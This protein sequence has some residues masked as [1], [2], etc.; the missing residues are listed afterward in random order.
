MPARDAVELKL[1]RLPVVVPVSIEVD[2]RFRS[3]PPDA[4]TDV[5]CEMLSAWPVVRAFTTIDCPIPVVSAEAVRRTCVPA[6]D[7]VDERFTSAP[8]VVAV[9]IE[10]EDTLRSAPPEAMTAVV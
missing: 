5:V 2:E 10:V 1:R 9:S 3:E 4:M 8:D 7:A 6:V